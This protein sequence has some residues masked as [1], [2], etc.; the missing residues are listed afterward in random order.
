MNGDLKSA[1]ATDVP[2]VLFLEEQ[3]TALCVLYVFIWK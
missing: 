3:I 2:I 1:P